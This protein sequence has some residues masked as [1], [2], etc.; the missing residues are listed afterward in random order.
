MPGAPSSEHGLCAQ[1]LLIYNDLLGFL[2]PCF[3]LQ[4]PP[5]TCSDL[6][7]FTS[8]PGRICLDTKLAD[9]GIRP[10]SLNEEARW[11]I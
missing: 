7:G 9:R 8:A 6:W 2:Q 11:C 1:N 3:D 10:V 4:P 5:V